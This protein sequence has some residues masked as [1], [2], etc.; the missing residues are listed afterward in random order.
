MPWDVYKNTLE[1]RR[2]WAIADAKARVLVEPQPERTMFPPADTWPD[3]LVSP[4]E[5][6]QLRATLV[7]RERGGER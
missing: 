2:R 5:V 7:D 1:D 6:K 3:E 4:E